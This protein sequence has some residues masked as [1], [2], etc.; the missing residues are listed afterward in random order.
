MNIKH[1]IRHIP[2]LLVVA[3]FAIGCEKQNASLAFEIEM[4]AVAP[5]VCQNDQTGEP[6]GKSQAVAATTSE[7][8]ITAADNEILLIASRWGGSST[9]LHYKSGNGFGV[10]VKLRPQAILESGDYSLTMIGINWG[11]PSSFKVVVT[12]DGV[13]RAYEGGGSHDS[14]VV[15]SK[16]IPLKI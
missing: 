16:T 8:H 7:I 3:T 2:V 6:A 13:A 12:A 14:G 4:E 15:W 9:L 11:G 5:D 10:D 1:Q